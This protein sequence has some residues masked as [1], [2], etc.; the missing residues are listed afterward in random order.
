MQGLVPA[1][2]WCFQFDY[3]TAYLWNSRLKNRFHFPEQERVLF[4]AHLYS[5][6][7]EALPALITPTPPCR[8]QAAVIAG[9]QGKT[10]ESLTERGKRE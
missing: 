9:G 8:P 6:S 5:S 2:L 4:I 1:F 3:F 7:G 10:L